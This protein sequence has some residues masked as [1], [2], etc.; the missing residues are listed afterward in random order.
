SRSFV[1][2]APNRAISAGGT[3]IV[4]F[5]YSDGRGWPPAA[6]GA[7]HSLILLDSAQSA[8]NSGSAEYGGNW[9]AS[10][11]LKGSPGRADAVPPAGVVLNEIVAHTD[12]TSEFDSNDWI[13]L[14]NTTAADIPFGAG[15]YLSDDGA[16][17]TKW[18]I[19]ATN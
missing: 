14:Y 4:S 10:T 6:D 18:Q 9:R 16:S 15:W 1:R 19:P 5:N 7:G 11:Y 8:Q 3:D 12:F 2:S 13:E 17:L